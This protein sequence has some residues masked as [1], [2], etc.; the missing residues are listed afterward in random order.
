MISQVYG[1]CAT[2]IEVLLIVRSSLRWDRSF[3]L[4]HSLDS[5]WTGSESKEYWDSLAISFNHSNL[6]VQKKLSNELTFVRQHI[7]RL[8]AGRRFLQL[9]T[10]AGL[11][12]A[13][14]PEVSVISC[15]P[16][17][18][19]GVTAWICYPTREQRHYPTQR[20][21]WRLRSWKIASF[22]Y[23]GWGTMGAAEC[24]QSLWDRAPK[25]SRVSGAFVTTRLILFKHIRLKV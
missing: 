8:W 9:T 14:G 11:R 20:G 21:T 22:L 1:E 6:S 17:R 24:N 10:T 19:G 4:E 3:L 15:N 13:G 16:Q 5:I 12:A 2:V 7:Y 23:R 25:P 18:G